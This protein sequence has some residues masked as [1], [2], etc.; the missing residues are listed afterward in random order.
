MTTPET[1]IREYRLSEAFFQHFTRRVLIR[2]VPLIVL[3]TAVGLWIGGISFDVAGMSALAI[4]AAVLAVS[5]WYNVKRQHRSMR[6]FRV[7]VGDQSVTRIQNGFPELTL[8]RDQIAEVLE[9][10]T[11]LLVA[12]KTHGVR[13]AASAQI[14]GYNELK[15]QVAQ[16]HPIHPQTRHSWSA[17]IMVGSTIVVVGAMVVVYR[18]KD[19]R[20]VLAAATALS[21]ALI[22]C[23]IVI[24]R[25][26]AVDRRT[27]RTSWW[28][29]IVLFS[30]GTVAYSALQ[31]LSGR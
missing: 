9:T 5:M 16:L 28:L 26:P 8:T 21:L 24:Q 18:A 10:P 30:L 11:A 27:K 1:P 3:S 29:L 23:L 20:L 14:E 6:S 31:R 13:I 19:S 15:A 22:Y 17:P 25:S 7:R 12:A 4:I 2:I